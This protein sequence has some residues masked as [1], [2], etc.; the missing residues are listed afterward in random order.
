MRRSY[1][2]HPFPY[3]AALLLAL[4]FLAIPSI[5]QWVAAKPTFSEYAYL[6]A[7]RISISIQQKMLFPFGKLLSK[8]QRLYLVFPYYLILFL[9]LRAIYIHTRKWWYYLGLTTLA[10]L[11]GLFLFPNTLQL[12]ENNR[13]SK[14]IG[15]VANGRIVNSK[16]MYYRGANFTTYSYLCYLVGRT[17]VNEKVRDV[18]LDAY[19]ATA[20]T[21][22]N[23]TF[24]VGEI[25]SR[26]GGKFLPHRTHQ[27]GLSVDFMS[28]LLKHK[29]AY[30]NS[31]LFNLWGYR[32]EFDDNGKAGNI[33]LDYETM[34][35]HL[36]ALQQATKAKGMVIQKVIFDPVLR[37]YLLKTE[38]GPKIKK[39]PFT[40]NRVVVRHDDHYH[41]DFGVPKK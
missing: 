3:L 32:R 21:C 31:H 18:M 6:D 20:E 4:L 8:S 9:S 40:K 10:I 23:T 11:F 12:L 27:N 34:A 36:Y 24:V 37:P 41:V 30:R 13:A 39:L 22:P 29:K 16:R 35:K 1:F 5:S 19:A 38:Y 17:Y 15:H 25:G 14:S 7:S 2:K 26:K 33:E 28:P